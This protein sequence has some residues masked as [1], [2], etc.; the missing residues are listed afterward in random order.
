MC[1]SIQYYYSSVPAFMCFLCSTFLLYYISIMINNHIFSPCIFCNHMLII[2]I[3][4]LL[5]TLSPL[6]CTV[7]HIKVLQ[8]TTSSSY[9]VPSKNTI[10]NSHYF[11]A[12]KESH[13]SPFCPITICKPFILPLSILTLRLIISKTSL[14]C[15]SPISNLNNS[16]LEYCGRVVAGATLFGAFSSKL[17]SLTPTLILFLKCTCDEWTQVIA[18]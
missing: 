10:N 11:V 18:L 15:V 14:I 17:T 13:F 9:S 6:S 16:S 12:F 7:N 8:Q 4:C 1:L 2:I 5:S 3:M